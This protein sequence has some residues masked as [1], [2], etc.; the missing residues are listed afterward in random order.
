ML[1]TGVFRM[2][3]DIGRE[4]CNKSGSAIHLYSDNLHLTF[5]LNLNNFEEYFY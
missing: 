5:L 2:I 3:C 1:L 4:T